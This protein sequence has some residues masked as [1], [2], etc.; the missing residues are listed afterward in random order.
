[1][2]VI[3]I[4]NRS[5]D[6]QPITTFTVNIWTGLVG[7]KA[8][9]VSSLI[10]ICT[11]CHSVGTFYT[12]SEPSL[13]RQHL[14]PKMLPFK[15]ICCCKESLMDRIICKEDLALFLF[16]HRTCFGYLLELPQRGNSNKYPKHMLLEVLMQYSCI[17]SHYLSP[18]KRRFRDIQI[19]ILTNF[20]I[21]LSI[22][23]K[24]VDCITESSNGLVQILE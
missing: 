22:G 23:I 19:V 21:V 24:K 9:A 7:L 6:S 11:V 12:Y 14:F 3:M 4:K 16:P 10:R 15:W 5:K 1:M 20:V 18:L 2:P 17:I 13:Q 8:C